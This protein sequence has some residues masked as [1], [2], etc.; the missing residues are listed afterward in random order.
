MA[1]S[2]VGILGTDYAF[3]ESESFTV[4]ARSYHDY[5][6]FM[7]EGDEISFEIFVSG[8]TNDDIYFVL[9]SP[10][11]SKLNE[12]VIYEQFADSI[13]AANSGTYTFRFDNT[14]S[15]I[16][17]KGVGLSYALKV[18]T[19]I[20]YVEPLPEWATYSGN[21][22]YDA[23]TAWKDANP[24][25]NF[26]KADSPEEAN[27]R[28][29]WVKEFGVEH[30]GYAY[31]KQFI[32]VGLGDSNCGGQ[33]QPYSADHVGWIMKHEIGHVLGFEHSSDETSIMY[34]IA[35]RAEYG[36]VSKQFNSDLQTFFM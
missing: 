26:Y 16:S 21:A 33:W 12:G 9:Y 1:I 32:E 24:H 35:P 7:N 11:N 30:V 15:I 3:A 13:T 27:L 8:G 23:T 2:V 22:V 20:I 19:Y 6:I 5:Q 28:I 18:N 34:P 36:K 17:N 29:Q 10:T 14:D 4:A 25:L 31:G